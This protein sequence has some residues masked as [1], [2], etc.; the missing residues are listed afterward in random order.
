MAIGRRAQKQL[1]REG[2]RVVA[3]A[4]MPT[5]KTLDRLGRGVTGMNGFA[6]MVPSPGQPG[7]MGSTWPRLRQG[8]ALMPPRRGQSKL[9]GEKKTNTF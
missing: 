6:P 5:G 4:S 7:Q 9:Q 3:S 2:G 1:L 8:A